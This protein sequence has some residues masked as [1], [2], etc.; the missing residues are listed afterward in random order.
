MPYCL[1]VLL[2]LRLTI[3]SLAN[4]SYIVIL[5]LRLSFLSFLCIS[6]ADE[7][8][9]LPTSQQFLF[10]SYPAPASQAGSAPL[11]T[12]PPLHRQMGSK[13]AFGFGSGPSANLVTI[14]CSV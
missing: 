4:L 5:N 1:A 12:T 14:I 7:L 2:P 11:Y 3:H 8:V 6:D 13:T 9:L 10:P